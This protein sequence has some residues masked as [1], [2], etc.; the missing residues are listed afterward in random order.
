MGLRTR[1]SHELAAVAFVIG[2]L[3]AGP[4][5]PAATEIVTQAAAPSLGIGGRSDA[6]GISTDGRYVVFSSEASNLAAND[7]NERADIFVIDRQT[8]AIQIASLDSGGV[9]G[10]RSS[11]FPAISGDGQWVAFYSEATNLVAGDSNELSDLFLRNLGTGSTT[12]ISVDS[13]GTQAD[14]ANAYDESP[15][16][17]GDGRY[18][19]FSSTATNLVA[20]DGNGTSD[21]FVHDRQSGTTTR[22]SVAS[23]G[24][25]G[26][27][28]SYSPAVSADGRYVAFLSAASNLVAGDTNSRD[29]VFVHDR[30]TGGT[31]RVSIDSAGAQANSYSRFPA[32]S[33]DGRF[34]A[35]LSLATNLVAGDTNGTVDV[36]VHDRQSG[37]TS[38]VSVSSNGSQGSGGTGVLARLSISPDGRFVVYPSALANLVDGDTNATYDVFVHDRQS[39]ATSLVSSDG[40]GAVGRGPSYDP[41]ISGDGR[42]VAF[43]SL[44]PNLVAG[45]RNAESDIFVRD[46]L[47]GTISRIP[48]TPVAP[49]AGALVLADGA[50]HV[51]RQATVGGRW[52][53]FTSSAGNLVAGDTNASADVFVRD[54]QSQTTE[55][56]SLG[57]GGAQA[58]ADSTDGVISGDGRYVAFAS[59]ATHLVAGDLNESSD[60]FLRDRQSGTT[61]RV[62]IGNDGGEA[63]AASS[64]PSI[65]SDGRYVAFQSEA[66]NLVDGEPNWVVDVF[67]RDRQTGQTQLV[68]ADSAGT[69]GDL[70][71]FDPVISGDGRYVV[72]TSWASNLIA[73]Q[74]DDDYYYDVYLKDLVSGQVERISVDSAGSQAAGFSFARAISSGGRFVVFDSDAANLDPSD[75]NGTRDVFL[76]DRQSG[77]TTRVSVASSG[78]EANDDSLDGSVSADGRFVAFASRA[79]NLVAGDTNHSWDIF[80]RD[81]QAGSTTRVSVAGTLAQ[82][83]AGSW[84]TPT[85]SEDGRYVVF[86]SWAADLV[87]GDFNGQSDVFVHDRLG[88][89][90]VPAITVSG[91]TSGQ[92]DQVLTFTATAT[93]CAPSATGWS[94]STSGAL[95]AGETNGPSISLSWSFAGTKTI[96]VSNSACGAATGT[97]N[98]TISDGG[99]PGS[100]V[101]TA[102]AACLLDGRFQVDVD[103]TTGSGSGHGGVMTFAGARAESN[104]S[105]FFYFFDNANFEM[106]VKM[107]DACS[108]NDSFWVFVSGLTNQAYTVHIRDVA[109]GQT[110]SYS[111]PLGNYPQTIGATDG[112]SGFDCTPSGAS[113]P[114]PAADG[115][116]VARLL[117]A[118][119]SDP[120]GARLLALRSAAGELPTDA[121]TPD[122]DTACH[123]AGR[124]RVEVH[125]ATAAAAGSAAVMSF[126]GQRAASDQSSFWWFFQPTNFEMGVKM[127]DACSAFGSYWVFVS[128]LTNQAFEVTVTDTVNG[129]VRTFVNPAGTYPQTVGATDVVRGFPC[130]P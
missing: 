37:A 124:F 22:V 69:P 79:E 4:A 130:A 78:A 129:N 116:A 91:P 115:E 6:T 24:A 123:L 44:A 53:V 125:W 57:S 94:W 96:S 28:T 63:E 100:C 87:T 109:T 122:A 128:G 14:G 97:H 59:S 21:V 102:N 93:N 36:F 70:D 30:T 105:V 5:R 27:D 47:A 83:T 29:D 92:T 108:F 110:R 13:S 50:S 66:E 67:V 76:R 95:P 42:V 85:V 68:S 9:Q 71:S 73:G 81:R 19:A 119:P 48:A 17:S 56:V 60:I 33:A 7:T 127:V 114:Q 34:V 65:S 99:G 8:G 52:V 118:A 18:V 3:L 45:D 86:D 10:N 77:T 121:C 106:G 72:F 40:G 80:L 64:R 98:V 38:R 25:A 104:Q 54:R 74:T 120:L 20:G 43:A 88:S 90:V 55:R 23:G 15:S 41:A 35:F 31:W 1:R 12:R 103:W 16:L 61:S 51:S 46:R 39:G 101:P 11:S 84:A 49:P 32:I 26:N 2:A 126:A 117:A 58:D 112:T 82:S 62:S 107:V 89:T 113:A 111:N 75:F